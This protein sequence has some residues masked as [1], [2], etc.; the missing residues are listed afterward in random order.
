MRVNKKY[1]IIGV[2]VVGLLIA[3][4]MSGATTTTQ[5]EYD[6]FKFYVDYII[7]RWEGTAYENVKGDRGKGTKFGI[8]E[9]DYPNIDI[10]NLSR[11][12]AID[13]YWTDY[14]KRGR[15]DLIPVEIQFMQ[16]AGTV[17]FGVTGQIKVLQE[18]AGVSK[19]GVIGTDTLTAAQ[20]VSPQ[21]LLSAQIARYDR[22]LANDSSQQKFYAGWINR[23]RDIY[24]QQIEINKYS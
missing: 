17:N 10:K 2:V 7:D 9:K 8:T 23:V 16:F 15:L 22:I 6:M 5:S 4:T 14:W 11:K 3:T 20:S 18:A 19:D 24:N 13:I 12:R 1:I 21:E